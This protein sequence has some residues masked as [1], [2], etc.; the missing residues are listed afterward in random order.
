MNHTI[1]DDIISSGVY[2]NKPLRLP[3]NLIE[4]VQFLA[5][6]ND[7]SLN[8]VVIQCIEYALEHYDDDIENGKEV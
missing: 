5:T 4:Q 6:E 8:R 7:M 1:L 3:K 2:E